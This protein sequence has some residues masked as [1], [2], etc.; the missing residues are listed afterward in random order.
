VERNNCPEQTLLKI[1]RL[2]ILNS[3]P[4][5]QAKR[6]EQLKIY[7]SSTEHKEHLRKL[8]ERRSFKV[9]IFDTE[10]NETTVYS[11]VRVAAK[12]IGCA[13]QTIHNAIKTLEEKGVPGLIKK[14]YTVKRIAND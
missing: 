4:E 3:N 6:L 2:K 5:Q 14:R 13:P 9:E 12:E 1:E 8:Q 10:N 7:T 11:S